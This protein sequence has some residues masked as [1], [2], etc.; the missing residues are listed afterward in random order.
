MNQER[1]GRVLLG[2]FAALLIVFLAASRTGAQA[3]A[4]FVYVA[5]CGGVG[6]PG[7]VGT[8]NVSA[9]TMD[10]TTGVLTPVPGSPFT[11]GLG[12]QGVTVDPLG[13]FTYV[14]N[15]QSNNVSAYTID[16][17]TGALAEV[18]GSPFSSGGIAPRT[19]AIDPSGQFAY[20][21]NV[22]SNNVAAFTIDPASGA[23]APVPGSPFAAGTAPLG[24]VVHPAGQFVYVANCG[25]FACQGANAGSISAY[26]IDPTSGA[27]TQIIGSPF[28]AGTTSLWVTVDPSG[29][30]A[31]ATNLRSNN[32]SAYSV[33]PATGALS[34]MMGSPFSA[35]LDP[36]VVAVD[37]TGQFAYVSNC[38]NES[39]GCLASSPGNVS[40]YTIDA[41]TGALSPVNGSPFAAG[42][43]SVFV[44]VAPTGQFVYVANRDTND[45]SA[46]VIDAMTGALTP[47]TSSPFLA[48]SFPLAVAATASPPPSPAATRPRP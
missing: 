13:R 2:G 19:V 26:A 11:T 40:A 12:P 22:N 42:T 1:I 47:V 35:G 7:G 31:Y 18:F 39:L 24:V 14:A 41:T 17:A 8:G 6:C 30:F 15:L 48:G 21:A 46:F 34:E 27:L 29:Q 4:G 5:N 43:T 23:L 45:V 25:S 38:G 32:V 9:Y 44:T 20:V 28:A 16:P 33:D 36:V 3:P 10:G 37:P